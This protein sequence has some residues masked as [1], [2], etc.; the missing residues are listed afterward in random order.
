M[1]TFP[2]TNP[3]AAA[4]REIPIRGL[5]RRWKMRDAHCPAATAAAT[6]SPTTLPDLTTR[7]LH[8]RGH[9][10]PI[11]ADLLLNPK[12]THLHN[13]SLI[14]DLDRAAR[15]LL[16]ALK[17]NQLV[18]IFGDYDVDGITAS[19]I[20]FH[21][22]LTLVPTA[23]VCT[24]VP[25]RID[26]GYGLNSA[27]M[28]DLASRGVNV[29]VTVDCGVTAIEPARRARELGIDLIITDHHNP[30][31]SLADLPDAF[32]VVHPRRPDSTYPFGELSGAGVAYKLA[33]AMSVIDSPTGR[34]TDVMRAKLIDLL[35]FAALGAIADVVPLVGENRVITRFGLGR[36]RDCDN[37]G[38]RALISA[39]GLDGQRVDAWDVGFKLAPR[40]N[41][42]GRMAHAQDAV[43]LFTTAD[44]ARAAVIA[45]ALEA[46]NRE[47]RA[48]ELTILEQAIERADAAGMTRADRRA[49]VLADAAWHQGVVGIV[50]SRLV[51][52][53]GRPA[54]LM[55]IHGDTAH[56]SARSIDGFNLHA[57][58]ADCSEHLVSFG[59]HDMAAG[60]KIRIDKLPAFTEAFVERCNAGITTD[61]LMR[62]VLIDCDAQPHELTPSAVKQLESLAPFGR[63]HAAPTILLR[64]LVL[65]AAPAPLG[66]TGDHLALTVRAA[67]PAS[68]SL[69]LLRIIAWRWGEHRGKLQSGGRIDAVVRPAISTFS[70]SPT[71]EPELL[72]LAVH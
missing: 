12:L 53:F 54:I 3:T 70:G 13:P 33:W 52:R 60:L 20:L 5:T 62:E 72:D 7:L 24:Y 17:S 14:P 39:A 65:A 31:A 29:I 41:A 55:Q 30:P 35:A 34:A 44:P 9:T 22:F 26:E 67:R 69:K 11:T 25:H 58:I 4:A 59:G 32:A 10:D 63:G 61:Q 49:I 45:G 43:E 1:S 28:D 64:D 46:Q 27:A 71:V 68:G 18:A 40:L 23:R 66:K 2:R 21:T 38:M 42:S 56:G 57:A 8:A 16:D 51:D 19:A 37:A 6:P 48:V 36:V 15:R 50:C 47:R